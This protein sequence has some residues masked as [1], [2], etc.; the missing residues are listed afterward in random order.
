MNYSVGQIVYL[1]SK[2][3]TQVFPAQ[4]VEQIKRKT[5]EGESVDYTI[6]LPDSN[7][8]TISISEIDSQVFMSVESL[9]SFMIENAEKSIKTM[10]DKAVDI[11]RDIFEDTI[12]DSDSLSES[13]VSSI[14]SEVDIGNGIKAKVNIE[15]IKDSIEKIEGLTGV[16]DG[17]S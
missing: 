3:T 14:P 16:S 9:R 5:L 7:R 11:S 17:T 4:V 1:I 10:I 15:S 8:S 6:M 13:L 12:K 2:K